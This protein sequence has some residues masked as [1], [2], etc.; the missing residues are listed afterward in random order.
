[1]RVLVTGGSG[2]IGSNVV[3]ELIKRGHHPV[4]LDLNIWGS[5]SL[6]VFKGKMTFIEGDCRNSKDVIY[7]LDGVDAVIHLAGIV[8]EAACLR[9]PKAHFSVN[10]E[11]TRTLLNCCTDPSL[12]LTR[13]LIYSSSCSVYGNVEGI[14]SEVHEDMAVNPL[15]DYAYAKVRSEN[16][17]LQKGKEISHFHPTVLRLSTVFGWSR[18][19]RLDLVTNLFAYNAWKDKKITIN[20]DGAQYRSL[21]H[22]EDVA[23]AFVDVLESPRFMRDGKVFHVGEE[24]NNMTVR[25][26]AELTQSIIEDVSIEYSNDSKTDKRDYS[27]NCRKIKNGI[28]WQAQWSVCEGMKDLLKKFETEKYDLQSDKYRNSTYEYK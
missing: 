10:V 22:V 21:V 12:E 25:E 26:I 6:D 1:M 27:I 20:G 5:E 28:G 15:S 11:S 3:G 19:P 16:M 17:I 23:R 8:G 2:Y 18:R 24:K 9:N 14:Y 7:A 13:D 4:V